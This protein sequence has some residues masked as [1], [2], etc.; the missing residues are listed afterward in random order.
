VN[1]S[2]PES[3]RAL[4]TPRF[5]IPHLEHLSPLSSGIALFGFCLFTPV[6]AVWAQQQPQQLSPSEALRWAMDPFDQAR[7]QNGDLTDADKLALSLGETRAA[8]DC[9]SL[10]SASPSAP[11]DPAE[12]LALGKLCLFGQQFEPARATLV[13]YLAL[14]SPPER[15]TALILLTR[16]F[17]GLKSPGSAAVQVLSLV[18]DYPYDANIHS[19]ADQVIS[20]CEYTTEGL[21]TYVTQLCAKQTE[22]TLPLLLNGKGLQG[23]DETISPARLFA[24]ALRCTVNARDLGNSAAAPSL[25]ALEKV[26]Q[27]SS[28]QGTADQRL[29]QQALTR[30]QMTGQAPP[31]PVLHA[32]QIRANQPPAPRTLI[33]RRGATVL[34]FFT[35]WSPNAIQVI[36]GLVDAAPSTSIYA[37][38]TWSANTGGK[39]ASTPEILN[40]LRTMSQGLPRKVPLLIV[41][42]AELNAF[43][44]DQFPAAVAIGDGVVLA[45]VVLADAGSIR[46]ALHGIHPAQS[47]QKADLSRQP[48]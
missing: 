12:I 44:L 14:P 37:V 21:E 26:A 42:D 24:D 2:S 9:L 25:S 6:L 20:A 16:A 1:E 41:P 4:R 17:L 40:A 28:W 18:R 45:N 47:T 34:A 23:K 35:L 31:L 19:T 3:F 15:E 7:S 39:D 43:H 22:T 27:Q 8:Q 13:R 38:T 32:R 10:T 36:H 29:V 33:L 46:M 5:R 30:A 48:R 11:L